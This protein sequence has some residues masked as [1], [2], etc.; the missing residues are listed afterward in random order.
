MTRHWL[1]VLIAWLATL[2]AG[3]ALAQSRESEPVK[4]VAAQHLHVAT[5]RGQGDL[6][7]YLSADWSRPLPTVTRAVIVVHGA[8]RNADIY[9]RSAEDARAVSGTAPETVLLIVPQFL[10]DVD[11]SALALPADTLRWTL[12]GWKEGQPALGPAP[13]SSFDAFDTVLAHL[14]DRGLFP[15]LRQVVLAGHSAGAQVVQ[16]Y[17]VAGRGERALTE[18]GV[19]MRYVVANP[20]SYLWFGDD[21]PRPVDRAACPTVDQWKY[22]LRDAPPYVG[23]TRGL[24]RR[25]IMRDVVY[26]L[27]DA[28]TDPNHASLDRSCAAMAQGETRFARGMQYRHALEVRRPNLVR[29]RIHAIPGVGHD[30]A[31]MFASACGMAALFGQT[32]CAGL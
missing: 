18:R 8:L 17:A 19:G 26:L 16:R 9:L 21:R 15:S 5:P 14:A 20:S 10:T 25:F 7:V 13:L 28:D 31:R 24:E 22:G 6:P 11:T 12:G 23:E 32:G 2:R 27:G 3:P 30:N 4:A 29:H 1:L